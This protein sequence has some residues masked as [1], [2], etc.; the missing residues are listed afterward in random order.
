MDTDPLEDPEEDPNEDP[1][2]DPEEDPEEDLDQDWVS[3]FDKTNNL[4]NKLSVEPIDFIKS[5]IFY[6]TKDN[7]IKTIK[8]DVIQLSITNKIKKEDIFH[9]IVK[10]KNNYKLSGI[11]LFTINITNI[12]DLHVE[13]SESVKSLNLIDDIDLPT[14]LNVYKHINSLIILFTEKN[15]KNTTKKIIY[16]LKQQ[17]KT[18][19]KKH[20]DNTV[21]KQK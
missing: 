13:P 20:T 18:R 6:I 14:T 17:N 3:D 4:Y 21:V 2:E 10:N 16:K 1:N 5:K 19:S 12:Q 7:E 8:N 15:K 11:G 9:H